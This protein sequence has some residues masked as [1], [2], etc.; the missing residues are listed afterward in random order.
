MDIKIIDFHTHPFDSDEYN[1]CSHSAYSDMSFENTQR[2][3]KKLGI[4]RICGSVIA[5]RKEKTEW[6]DIRSLND[7]ALEMAKRYNGFYIPG[8][9]VHPDFVR[10]SCEEIERMSKL[11]VKLIGELVP[12]HHHWNDYSDKGFYEILDTAKSYNMVV[13]FHSMNE[14]SMDK[15]V[16]DNKDV[17]FVAAHPGEYKEFMRHLERMKMSENYHLDISGTGV[18]RHGMLRHAIDA[19]GV[20]RILLGSDYPTCNPAMFVHAVVS[21]FL[22]KDYEKDYIC[23]KN[24]ERLLNIM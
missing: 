6:S 18:F 22:I 11:G 5:K 1:I 9:H 24:C 4:S 19:V 20:E 15:M 8:F 21:D 14:D 13:S 17:T 23:S 12:Y 7:K 2:D 16:N 10:E 3:L